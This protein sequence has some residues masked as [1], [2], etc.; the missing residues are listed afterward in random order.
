VAELK[1]NAKNKSRGDGYDRRTP[2][3]PYPKG[4]KFHGK[5]TDHDVRA[6]QDYGGKVLIL[7]PKYS[8][9]DHQEARKG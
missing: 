3:K 7:E 2:A 9:A 8:V 4:V 1:P 5:S 6:V